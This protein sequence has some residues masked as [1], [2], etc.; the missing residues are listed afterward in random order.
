MNEVNPA[1]SETT[2]KASSSPTH[3]AVQFD[4]AQAEGR[5]NVFVGSGWEMI[6]ANG[7]RGMRITVR[8]SQCQT[9]VD[10]RSGETIIEIF[11]WPHG[12]SVPR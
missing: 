3:Y 5:Q 4:K 10:R 12:R 7:K 8:A 1:V 2:G 9:Y 11:V 6:G